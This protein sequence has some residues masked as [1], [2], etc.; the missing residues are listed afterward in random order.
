MIDENI[1]SKIE[2]YN[3]DNYFGES[4]NDSITW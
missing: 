4:K 1:L 2:E 3:I